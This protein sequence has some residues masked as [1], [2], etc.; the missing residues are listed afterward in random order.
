MTK[1]EFEVIGTLQTCFREK[2]GVPRQSGLVPQADGILKLNDHPFLKTAMRGM[3][4]FSHVWVIF[5]FHKHAANNW[6]PSIRPPR[7]GGARKI[8]VL[9]SRSPHRPNPIGLSVLKLER[10]DYEAPGGVEIHLSGVDILDGTPVLDIK[11]YLA[12]ADSVPHALAGW[13]SDPIVR[14]PVTFTDFALASIE[15]LGAGKYPHLKQ[16]IT[17]MVELDPRPAFQKTRMPPADD[18][19]NGTR[20]GFRLFEFDIKWEI[21]EN[22]FCVLDVIIFVAIN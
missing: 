20:F 16:L 21:R 6:K 3:D 10:I 19:S 14:T 18:D 4:G 13:A 2:F 12:Y 1:L 15:R 17:E 9:A 7:L 8:G 11:P 22:G 5:V